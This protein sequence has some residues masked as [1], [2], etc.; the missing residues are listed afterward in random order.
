[1]KNYGIYLLYPPTVDLRKEGLGRYLASFLKGLKNKDDV[2]FKIVCPSWAKKDLVILFESEKVPTNCFDVVSPKSEPVI[3]RA[4]SWFERI[5]KKFSNKKKKTS[6]FEK[7]S[8]VIY[9]AMVR[10]FIR[11][12]SIPL[13]IILSF[14]LVALFPLIVISICFFA[15]VFILNKY[16]KSRFINS[17][18]NKIKNVFNRI[19]RTSDN[20]KKDKKIFN[21]YK[22]IESNE[23]KKIQ[24]LIEDMPEISA[25][26]CPTAFWPSFNLIAAPR[27]MCVPDVVLEEFPIGFAEGVGDRGTAAYLN[28]ITAIQG[29]DKFVTYSD[30][31]KW[32]T[33]VNN[34][35]I[36]PAKVSVI[37]HAPNDLSGFI[38]F[39][40]INDKESM[41]VQYCRTKIIAAIYRSFSESYVSAFDNQDIKFIFYASQTRPNK[42]IITLLRAY[43]YLL[44]ER[45]IE[46]KLILT[47]HP[48]AL[49]SVSDFVKKNNLQ[50]DVRFLHGLSIEELASFY[51]LADLAVNPSLSEGGCPFTFTEALSVGTPVVMSRISVTEEVLDNI[52]LQKYTFFD[53]YDCIDMADKIE[54]GLLNTKTLYEV[55]IK[56]YKKLSSRTW[57]D[58]VNEHLIILDEISTQ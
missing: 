56:S 3:L 52:D 45:G 55:Q 40:G 21:L 38:K 33:L 5:R 53:P 36:D 49:K 27:L 22:E 26:Y 17:F 48:D 20:V 12:D 16:V 51:K 42:N 50:D 4:H 1:M 18:F 54:W 28:V 47:G 24:K 8:L 44:R 2:R 23:I 41:A 7:Y 25:W 31:V 14:L 34:H 37:N 46:H 11:I 58:V 15:C 19:S 9:Q 32:A 29:G 57:E 13:F 10:F 30:H 43:K 6:L 39:D 35:S